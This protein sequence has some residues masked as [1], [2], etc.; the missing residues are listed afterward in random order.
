MQDQQM[1]NALRMLSVDAVQEANSGHPGL[2]LGAAPMAYTLWNQFLHVDPCKTDWIDRDR[3]V[4][5]AGHGSA[6]LYALLHTHGFDLS[7]DDLK[8]FRQL[9]SKTPGHPELHETPGVEAT[10]GPL[11][12]GMSMA[13]GMAIAESHL[14]E[15][16]RKGDETLFDHYTYVLASDGD[17]ME[18]VSNEAASIAGMLELNK[19]IVLYDSNEIS[20]EGNTNL[21]FRENVRDRFTALGWATQ[22]V[23]DGND[24]EAIARAIEAAKQEDKPSLIEVRTLIGYGSPRVGSEKSHG[25]PLGVDNVAM[26][27]T[28]LAWEYEP[29]A[30]PEGVSEYRKAYQARGAALSQ[31]W[32]EKK[33]R[34]FSAHP[35]M[36]ET[37]DAYFTESPVTIDPITFDKASATR[38]SASAVLQ[39]LA[40]KLPNLIGGSAD[41]GPSNKSVMNGRSSLSP[42]NYGGSNIH[43]GVR[44]HAMGAIANGMAIHGGLRP[45]VATFLIFSDFLKPAARL[46]ALMKLPVTYIFT[47]DSIGVGEDGPTHQPIEQL[48][49]FRSIP[50]MTVF[51]PADG[52]EAQAAWE[53]AVNHRTGPTM[54]ALSRQKLPQLVTSSKDIHRGGYAVN[55]VEDPELLLIA[56]G[57]EVAIAVE[58][59]EALLAEGVRARVVSIPSWE[60]Y[61]AQDAAYKESVLPKHVK[62]RIGIE[63]A[64]S[65]GWG[66]FL[67]DESVFIGMDTFGTSAPGDQVFDHFGINAESILKAAKALLEQ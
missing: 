32:E 8:N 54:L 64:D 5:S 59:A 42:D 25:E 1:I 12:H 4:L 40:E 51:R 10:T 36:K 61:C 62:K 41:L 33:D 52:R 24:T 66:R 46:A 34:F 31:A 48:T 3:F 17:M 44:E 2:P 26:T 65:F 63:A 9:G 7:I 37:F 60:V 6:L 56:T 15:V 28:E 16:F 13:V 22:L 49:M 23:E 58:A 43:F 55:E 20:I 18:G 11:G 19:L 47:H 45:Y 30:L 39:Q 53:Y 27:R 29:F 57:S 50:N 14:S 38:E 67:T 35:E 21:T